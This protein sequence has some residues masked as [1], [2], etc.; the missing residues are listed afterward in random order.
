MHEFSVVSMRGGPIVGDGLVATA[1]G[2]WK[3][4]AADEVPC[5]MTIT[6]VALVEEQLDWTSTDL[7]R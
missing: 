5:L 4:L 1:D 6:E 3:I 2:T 7:M